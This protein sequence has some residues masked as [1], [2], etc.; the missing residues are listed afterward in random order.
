LDFVA[1][2]GTN[3]LDGA[4]Q[5]ALTRHVTLC[6]FISS[7]VG[8]ADRPWV[9]I[10][11]KSRL[12]RSEVMKPSALPFMGTLLVAQALHVSLTTCRRTT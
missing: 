1:K 7:P 11:P 8:R 5:F 3:L 6:A 4:N 2:F 12:Q 9:S 10:R